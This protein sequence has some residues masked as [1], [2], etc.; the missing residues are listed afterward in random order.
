M[1]PACPR[2]G[3][4]HGS[5]PGRKAQ[6]DRGPAAAPVAFGGGRFLF[7]SLSCR[8]PVFAP[9]PPGSPALGLCLHA[10]RLQPWS[11]G[12][13]V[14]VSLWQCEALSGL[15]PLQ[16]WVSTGVSGATASS[17]P[18]ARGTRARVFSRFQSFL[19]WASLAVVRQHTPH[20]HSHLRGSVGPGDPCGPL[21]SQMAFQSFSLSLPSFQLLLSS[22]SS[23]WKGT[24]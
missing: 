1:R 12:L 6:G 13:R 17:L 19:F 9:L 5:C 4:A 11:A 7:L 21:F 2:R 23:W 14:D 18:W 3:V 22:A 16:S 8:Q 20:K 24:F 10:S 15:R